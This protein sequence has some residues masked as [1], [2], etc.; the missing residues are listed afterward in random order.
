MEEFIIISKIILKDKKWTTDSKI[1]STER[2]EFSSIVIT[3]VTTSTAWRRS[4]ICTRRPS[5]FK[6]L[7]TAK[8]LTLS[9]PLT[10]IAWRRKLFKDRDSKWKTGTHPSVVSTKYPRCEQQTLFAPNNC[11]RK[12]Q[13]PISTDVTVIS[14]TVQSIDAFTLQPTSLFKEA[15]RKNNRWARVVTHSLYSIHSCSL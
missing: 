3:F 14:K 11:R 12:I 5:N 13:H 15:L 9:A 7:P 10:T 1:K 6:D 8:I 2:L 4:L